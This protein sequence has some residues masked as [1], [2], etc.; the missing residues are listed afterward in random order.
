MTDIYYYRFRV[1]NVALRD[2]EKSIVEFR[3]L[4]VLVENKS[5]NLSWAKSVLEFLTDWSA[6]IY[7]KKH[8]KEALEIINLCQ[9]IIYKYIDPN[10]FTRINDKFTVAKIQYFISINDFTSALKIALN[11]N[12]I[13]ENSLGVINSFYEYSCNDIG[14]I[15]EELENGKLAIEW[16]LK[17]IDSKESRYKK[18]KNSDLK[19]NLATAYNNIS[20]VYRNFMNDP[21]NCLKYAKLAL[22]FKEADSS[23]SYGIS[24][25]MLGRAYD[26]NKQYKEA[27]EYY[28]SANKLF[29]AGTNKDIYQRAVLNIN[30]GITLSFV[31]KDK[32]K[33]LLI[34]NLSI[35]KKKDISEY[36]TTPIKNRIN[37]AEAILI[38]L[39][40]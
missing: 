7:Y 1:L 5:K 12:S 32:S 10:S 40:K 15:H 16:K 18:A 6:E 23:N 9:K 8:P 4:L 37:E 27:V 28:T 33:K 3:E 2:Y 24:L 36:I 20:H 11:M 14:K 19:G 38:T 30:L 26:F 29:P 13:I 21:E 39:S 17:A 31:D 22:E 25:Y 35:F 34:E